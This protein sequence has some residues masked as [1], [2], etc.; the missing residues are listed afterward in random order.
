MSE[1]QVTVR[2]VEGAP[3][4]PEPHTALPGGRAIRWA[5]GKE[6]TLPA[7]DARR[8]LRSGGRAFEVV[9]PAAAAVQGSA[10]AGSKKKKEE[11]TR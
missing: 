5:A 1:T 8:V 2:Y 7:D 6:V 11:E 3:L 4:G 10:T 9:R